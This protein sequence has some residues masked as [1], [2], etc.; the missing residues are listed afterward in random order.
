MKVNLVIPPDPFLGDDRRNPPL[1]IL[2]VAA[3]TRDAGYDVRLTD[4]RGVAIQ[5]IQDHLD[6]D[7][8]VYGFSASTPSYHIAWHIAKHIKAK[9]GATTVLGGM[10]GTALPQSIGPE[11]D[12]IV[13]GE[14]EVAFLDLLKDVQE[15]EA[16]D[17]QVY[18]STA[19]EDLDAISFPARDLLPRDAVFSRNAFSVDGEEAGTL[20]TSRGC[21]CLCSFCGSQYI[22]GRRVRFRT[23][24]NVVA[25]LQHIIDSYGV[26]H[27]RFQD[28]TMGLRKARLGELCRR[29][30]PLKIRWRATTRV[31][32]ADRESLAQMKKAGCEEVGFG[33]ESLD[34]AVLDRNQKGITLAQVY[35]AMENTKKVG[36]QARLFFII[37]LP[38]EKPGFADRL[39]MFLDKTRPEG[40]DISTLVPYPGSPVFHQ[41]ETFGITL[42][43][44]EFE[45]YHMT[46]GMK[47][48]ELTRPLTF[49]HDIMSE[50][51]IQ[52]EREKSLRIVKQRRQIRNF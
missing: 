15:D 39:E 6:M 12:K 31:D 24:A 19:I 51:E 38:G 27:F 14:G 7:S 36:L 48:G 50:A 52:E 21:P 9:T 18:Q 26:T 30:A 28:D 33:I 17:R 13:V 10:H 47:E 5:D 41:P 16:A 8:D 20:I 23:P 32:R 11:F 37:G 44:H 43:N 1:G 4:L 45:K 49:V 46:L 25:E 2:Y 40:V 34:Q 42:K 3:S 22:W 29:I 35:E